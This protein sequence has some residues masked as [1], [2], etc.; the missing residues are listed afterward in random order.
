MHGKRLFHWPQDL[1]PLSF[2]DNSEQRVLRIIWCRHGPVSAS[3]HKQDRDMGLRLESLLKAGSGI[4]TFLRQRHRNGSL[5][6]QLHDEAPGIPCIRF[7]ACVDDYD[8][9]LA[10]WYAA[11][12]IDTPNWSSRIVEHFDECRRTG[13]AGWYGDA[14]ASFA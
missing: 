13:N 7:D 5:T 8:D 2:H 10:V 14:G 12:G 11:N 4:A 1:P 3:I 9:R 6:I